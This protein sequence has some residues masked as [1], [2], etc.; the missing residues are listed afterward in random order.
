MNSVVNNVLTRYH[1]DIFS[2]KLGALFVNYVQAHHAELSEL[3][4]LLVLVKQRPPNWEREVEKFILR[5]DK[6]AFALGQIYDCLLHEYKVGF[7]SERY[8]PPTEALSSYGTSETRH[9][10][11]AA[12]SKAHREGGGGH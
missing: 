3:L 2:K 11:E 7:C 9:R 5:E 8:P 10:G 6:N 4:L 1:Q 12:E